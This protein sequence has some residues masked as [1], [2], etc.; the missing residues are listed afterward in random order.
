MTEPGSFGITPRWVLRAEISERARLLYGL[1][2]DAGDHSTLKAAPSR[3]ALA[4]W[5]HV[6]DVKAVDRA[7]SEL[8]KIGALRI[9]PRQN[10]ITRAS[11]TNGYQ[12]Y[13]TPYGTNGQVVGGE[14]PEP[15]GGGL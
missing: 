11:L 7:L 3:R 9:V 8:E 5:L 1:L 2:A 14:A 4:D 6:A 13:R 12:L 10:P 15:P